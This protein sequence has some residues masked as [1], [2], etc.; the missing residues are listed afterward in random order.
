MKRKM[1]MTENEQA[2]R[3]ERDMVL[4]AVVEG[5]IDEL[6]D[7]ERSR[8]E[9]VAEYMRRAEGHILSEPQ[10]AMILAFC[11][12]V[13][14]D[15]EEDREPARARKTPREIPVGAPVPL[16]DVLRRLPLKPPG[17]KGTL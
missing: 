13:R 6:D 2:D 15:V 16:P 17:W 10:R 14:P 8:A 7:A 1:S 3:R 5:G 9:S 4:L 12:I 11:R